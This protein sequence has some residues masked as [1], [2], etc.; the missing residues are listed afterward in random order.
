M[1][2]KKLKPNYFCDNPK[3][4]LHVEVASG[5]NTYAFETKG[6]FRNHVCF[7]GKKLKDC[8]KLCD[9]CKNAVE[10]VSIAKIKLKENKNGSSRD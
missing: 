2:D 6:V 7:L 9:I 4:F 8:F 1:T 3:C 5:L 10:M